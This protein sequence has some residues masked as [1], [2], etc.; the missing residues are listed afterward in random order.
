VNTLS[1][2]VI[3]IDPRNQQ[4]STQQWNL[5]VQT[6]L[7][8]NWTLQIG[9]AGTHSIHQIM[10]QSTNNGLLVNSNNPG[11]FGLDVNSGANVNSRV[12]V[13]GLPDYG[14]SD[15]T[16]NGKTLYNALLLTLSHRFSKGLYLKGAYTW[17]KALDNVPN[18]IGFEPGI[19]SNGNQFLPD[20]NYGLSNYNIPQ[21]LIVSYV[22]DLPGPKHGVSSYFIGNWEVAGITTLQSGASEEVDQFSLI[23]L[24]GTSGYGVVLPGCKLMSSGSVSDHLSDYLNSSCVTTQAVLNAGQTFGPLSPLAGPGSQTYTID[25]SA[26]SS[27]QLMGDPTRGDFHNPFQTREDLAL[28]KTFPV[29]ALGEQ[30]SIQFIAQAFKLFNTPIFSGPSAYANFS[31]FGHISSTID[32][33]GRQLQFALRVNF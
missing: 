21:R 5:S 8:K 28:K 16:T 3:E 11:P 23:S 14:I 33:T 22:Y 19:G 4:P 29:H 27:G 7:Y 1:G 10:T 6:E 26:G 17:S 32:N 30:G 31:S 2:G 12:P 9:Y 24:T 15:L 18:Y 13:I 25:P 20:L